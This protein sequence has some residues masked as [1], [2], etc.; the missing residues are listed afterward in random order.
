MAV[1]GVS[2]EDVQVGLGRPLSESEQ[3]QA[4]QWIDDAELLIRARLGDLTLLDAD[5]L[6]YVVR[7]AVVARMR[8]P[9]AYQSET[10]DDYTYRMP[11]ESRRL[12]ILD[13]WWNMLDPDTGANAFSVRPSFDPDT[14]RWPTSVGEGAYCVSTD[15]WRE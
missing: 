9:E 10:I 4:G 6:A 11:S 1:S 13:E 7:E 14:A 2:W 8:N 5:N 15:G 12:T 3:E